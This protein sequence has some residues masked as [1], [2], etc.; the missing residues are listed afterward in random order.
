MSNVTFLFSFA[1]LVNFSTKSNC[2]ANMFKITHR[3]NFKLII[4]F[5][6]LEFLDMVNF[7]RNQNS[8][9]LSL[10]IKSTMCQVT[11]STFPEYWN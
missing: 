7:V 8:K 3:N 9:Y 5:R 6:S 1:L 4:Q 11:L 2:A 10:K